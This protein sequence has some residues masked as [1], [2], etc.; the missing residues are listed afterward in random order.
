LGHVETHFYL[1]RNNSRSIAYN[2]G[3]VVICVRPEVDYFNIKFPDS[4][5]GWRRRWLYVQEE[6]HNSQ[7]YNI[8][9]FD[10]AVKILRR[11]SWD[12]EATAGEKAATD[13]LMKHIHELQ[14]TRSEE[15]SGVQ[16]TVYFLRIRVQPL[17]A[18]NNPLWMYAGK[19]DVD[20]LSK[21][22]SVKDL[23]KL[24]RRF[25]SISKKNE[26]PTSCRVEPYSGSHALPEVSNFFPLSCTFI[27][28]LPPNLFCMF[29]L[30]LAFTS[31]RTTKF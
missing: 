28:R 7:E 11:R 29:Y 20:R 6:Y 31:C 1:R 25:S 23:E 30:D 2:V 3:G 16:I 19:K 10:G 26:V 9:P 14:N 15:L 17:Q 18:S 12:A 24:I 5:Q 22:L 27:C 21:D 8:A 13:A 4:V